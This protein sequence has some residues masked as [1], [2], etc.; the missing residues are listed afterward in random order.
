MHAAELERSA[1]DAERSY[2]HAKMMNDFLISLEHCM[3]VIRVTTTIS[4]EGAPTFSANGVF[5][6][7]ELSLEQRPQISNLDRDCST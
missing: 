6:V 1:A 4:D 7:A 2:E 5:T 3:L